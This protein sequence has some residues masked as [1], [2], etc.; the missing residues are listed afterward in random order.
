MRE[1]LSSVFYMWVAFA[2]G[3][4]AVLFLFTPVLL[5]EY[6]CYVNATSIFWNDGIHNGAWPAFI[7]YMLILVGAIA[8]AIIALP[9]VQPSA[10]VEKIVLISSIG[11]MVVGL[12]AVGLLQVEYSALNDG[13]EFELDNL[14]YLWG[15]YV[16]MGCGVV[17]VGMDC[18]ALKMD[19]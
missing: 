3:V 6:D 9:I 11:C 8:S 13:I 18:V 12:I 17:A 19:W 1:K 14:K 10:K 5:D 7:G 4:I 15:W 16:T 2:L